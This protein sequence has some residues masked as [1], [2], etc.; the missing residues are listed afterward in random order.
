MEPPSGPRRRKI[1]KETVKDVQQYPDAYQREPSALFALCQKSICQVLKR[2]CLT[3]KNAASFQGRRR[4]TAPVSRQNSP[5]LK[6]GQTSGLFDERGFA[7]DMSS[8]RI[9]STRS[10][11]FWV[12]RLSG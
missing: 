3:Y 1:N 5:V 7:Y 4:G 6:A 2:W 8:L 9:F 10:A 11:L 12:P